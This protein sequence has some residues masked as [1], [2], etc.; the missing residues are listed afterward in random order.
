MLK[1]QMES[2]QSELEAR[3]SQTV[4]KIEELELENWNLK[5]SLS[6]KKETEEANR[7]GGT[8]SRGIE[9][10]NFFSKGLKFNNCQ[11]ITSLMVAKDV[12]ESGNKSQQTSPIPRVPKKVAVDDANSHCNEELESLAIVKESDFLRRQLQES[13]A[14]LS[15]ALEALKQNRATIKELK[16]AN[17]QYQQENSLLKLQIDKLE[18]AWVARS[19][20]NSRP[21]SRSKRIEETPKHFGKEESIILGRQE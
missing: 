16:E 21:A 8:P 2:K 1:E 10:T 20:G 15:K 18:K 6:A 5:Q 3:I 7:R 12:Q 14:N 9:E 11:E 19:R 13:Q 17:A 4:A